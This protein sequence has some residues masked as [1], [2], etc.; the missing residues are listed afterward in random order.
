MKTLWKQVSQ[1]F[2]QEFLK[3][4][5]GTNKVFLKTLR[6]QAEIK[7]FHKWFLQKPYD[8]NLKQTQMKSFHW[9]FVITWLKYF[10]TGTNKGFFI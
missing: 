8:K 9:G 7:S 10:E 5:T 1:G 3:N 4:K 2:S 6:K